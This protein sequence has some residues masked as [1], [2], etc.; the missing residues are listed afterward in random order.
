MF[1][2]EIQRDQYLILAFLGGGA[3]VLGWVLAHLALS[4]PRELGGEVALTPGDGRRAVLP[5]LRSFVPWVM[6]I[7]Y[8]GA[9][10]FVLVYTYMT[11]QNPPNW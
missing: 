6:V 4:R 11:W 10:A 9:V 1:D 2:I 5:W 3:L 7:V 8:A